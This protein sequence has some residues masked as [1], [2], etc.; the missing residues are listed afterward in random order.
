MARIHFFLQLFCSTFAVTFDFSFPS[1]SENKKKK[2]STLRI[3]RINKFYINVCVRVFFWHKCARFH[4]RHYYLLSRNLQ[5]DTQ[6]CFHIFCSVL[7]FPLWHFAPHRYWLKN[8][9]THVRSSSKSL[10][11]Y[12]RKK[13]SHPNHVSTICSKYR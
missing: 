3:R 4:M 12:G 5:S 11:W 6:F 10:F 7:F 13:A 8:Y 1:Q 9:C 2:T